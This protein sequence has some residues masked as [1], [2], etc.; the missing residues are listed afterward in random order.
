MNRLL[1]GENYNRIHTELLPTKE[2]VQLRNRSKNQRN[3]KSDR[4][5]IHKRYYSIYKEFKEWDSTIYTRIC[6]LVTTHGN[7]S[8]YN[9][10]HHHHHHH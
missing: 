7:D 4:L 3:S 5:N 8:H 10:F 2:I 9:L 1:L 6:E